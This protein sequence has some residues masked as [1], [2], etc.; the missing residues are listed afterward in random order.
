MRLEGT[1]VW[2]TVEAGRNFRGGNSIV[3]EVCRAGDELVYAAKVF[4]RDADEQSLSRFNSEI[5]LVK[6][7]ISIPGCVKYV[8]HGTIDE[9]PFYIMPFLKNGTF[10]TKYIN[11]A[12]LINVIETIDDFSAI[13]L[14]VASIHNL[15]LAIRDI[16]P[17]NI[18]LDDDNRPVLADFGL[19]MWIDTP[20][21]ERK[22]RI[23]EAVGSQGYRPPEWHSKYPNP[24]H[25]LGDIWSLGRTFWAMMARENAPNNYETLGGQSN[26]LRK[27]LPK[28]QALI[29]QG[30]ITSCTSQEPERRPPI[31]ELI[32]M[33][34]EARKQILDLENPSDQRKTLQEMLKKFSRNVE[35]SDI[36]IDMGRRESERN[37]LIEE[38]MEAVEKLHAILNERATGLNENKPRGIGDFR[39]YSPQNGDAFL[40]SK[41]LKFKPIR[42]LSLKRYLALRFDYSEKIQQHT[43]ASYAILYFYLGLT[44]SEKFYWVVQLADHGKES[45]IL[46]SLEVRSLTTVVGQKM[47]QIDQFIQRFLEIIQSHF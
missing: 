35:N 45:E 33:C 43:T 19:S 10:R 28:E 15:G 42:N 27:Y 32:D 36:Y 4:N 16:K 11:N 13:L 31:G 9:K 47:M 8:D 37:I 6:E 23:G 2:K 39:T 46:D 22:T 29:L 24:N 21:D 38:L 14:T 7:L 1:S 41:S 5:S 18:L 30:L 12:G 20:E 40:E 26:H 3:H 44:E 34:A 25:R 17:Q